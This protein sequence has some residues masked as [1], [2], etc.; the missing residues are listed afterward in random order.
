MTEKIHYSYEQITGI[1]KSKAKEIADVN[2]DYVIAIGGGGLIPARIVRPIVKK[3]IL[4]VTLALYN[5][6]DEIG[7]EVNIIQWID[8][9]LDLKDKKVLI[10]DEIDD[11]RKTM[12]YCVEKLREFNNAN[13]IS[14]FVVHNKLKD[15]FGELKDV[16]YIAGENIED[17]WVV[18]PWDE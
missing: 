11:T 17:K 6:D 10:I 8:K 12:L 3:P 5:S 14:I 9:S 7:E 2:P 13:N 18:Y 1:I 16:D 15:K 4:V